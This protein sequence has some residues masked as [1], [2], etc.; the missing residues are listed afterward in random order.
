MEPSDAPAVEVTSLR[1]G[2]GD[3]EAV[4]DMSFKVERG[5]IF[6]VIGP[7]GTG[8]TTAIECLEGL[9]RAGWRLSSRRRTGP[10][11]RS[12]QV[13]PHVSCLAFSALGTAITARIRNTRT[14]LGLGLAL[15]APMFVLSGAFG[16]RESFP[17]ALQLVGDWL[18]LTHA[19]D[20]LTF[21][22]LGGT[23]GRGND[24]R[25]AH[26][27][28]LCIPRSDSGGLRRSQCATVQV[29]LN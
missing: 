29:G 18:P 26:L 28:V 3:V 11:G 1:K 15:F 6:C 19:Y 9:C 24:Y 8:K 27:G 2:Y 13:G 5:S 7:N 20:L 4:D 12:R 14:A 23:C 25:R 21:L 16:P 22:W 17:D 10:H